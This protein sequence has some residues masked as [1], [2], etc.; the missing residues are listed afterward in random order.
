MKNF[1]IT[2]CLTLGAVFC[3]D[4]AQAAFWQV[5]RDTPVRAGTSADAKVLGSLKQGWIVSDLLGDEST[6]QWIKI[7]EFE[8]N[9]GEGMVYA[10][11]IFN[12]SASFVS[13]ADV[14]Q[15]N[16]DGSLLQQTENTAVQDKQEQGLI[17]N[18]LPT[19]QTDNA[20]L[21]TA[22]E[23]WIQECNAVFSAC[24]AME[25]EKAA[26][27]VMHWEYESPFTYKNIEAVGKSVE[28]L[29]INWVNALY[30]YP[31]VP[32]SGEDQ[33]TLDLLAEYGLTPQ[34]GEGSGYL[35]TDVNALSKRISFN[36]P[37]EQYDAYMK[38]VSS[39]PQKLFSDGGCIHSVTDMGIWAMQ[40]EQYLD[41]VDAN[42][43]YF[44]KGRDR[45]IEF[46]NF[47]LFSSLPNT[48]A[49][50]EHNGGKMTAEWMQELETLAKAHPETKTAALIKEFAATVKASGGKLPRKAY[51]ALLAKMAK[52][53]ETA[54]IGQ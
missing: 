14:M 48:P 39:Q 52:I 1:W 30:G 18:P 50:P 44:N 37:I 46:A 11:M 8:K 5:V 17:I 26:A 28:T 38:L 15:V 12:S 27:A 36:P 33:K 29:L 31:Q 22:L 40:W 2:S 51:D 21:N 53:P 19:P 43:I 20:A 35:E 24:Q 47:I 4:T 13:A 9:P 16:K 23:A 41:S 32:L 7:V 6:A 3:A 45:F 49:F 10:Y 25:P 42:S 34:F 54:A